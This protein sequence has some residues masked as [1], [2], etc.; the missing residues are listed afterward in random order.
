MRCP[1]C[2][3][4]QRK[5]E[6]LKL[7]HCN[8]CGR[9]HKISDFLR[10]VCPLDSFCNYSKNCWDDD[11]EHCGIHFNFMKLFDYNRAREN[12]KIISD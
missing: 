7:G 9:G 12:D 6:L 11:W 1:D 4:K 2:N 8:K 10:D 3:K 5:K